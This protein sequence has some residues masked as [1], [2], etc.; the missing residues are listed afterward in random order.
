MDTMEVL[1][2]L[3]SG[4]QE[5]FMK[6]EKLFETEGW[7]L[8]VDW[9]KAKAED[10]KSRAAHSSSWEENRVFVGQEAVYLM[11]A[12]LQSSSDAEFAALAEANAV[13]ELENSDDG[14]VDY[15]S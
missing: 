1:K 7:A 4:Q 13:S 14:A 6:L 5:R 2:N 11:V 3:D 8:V 15:Q 9:A 10:A 12:N